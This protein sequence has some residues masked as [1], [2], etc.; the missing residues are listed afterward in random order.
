MSV[1]SV[2]HNKYK[3][4]LKEDPDMQRINALLA[5]AGILKAKAFLNLY[6]IDGVFDFH[7]DFFLGLNS[8]CT[9][10]E[11]AAEEKNIRYC[12]KAASGKISFEA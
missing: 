1:L 2:M 3:E 7:R 8:S 9:P 10:E 11:D 12:H 6:G 4:R 5:E